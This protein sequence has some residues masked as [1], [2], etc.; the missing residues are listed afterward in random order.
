MIKTVIEN[1]DDKRRG[2]V[3]LNPA[4]IVTVTPTDDLH[5]A[6]AFVTPTEGTYEL[7]AV[8]DTTYERDRW[9]SVL[10]ER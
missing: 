9:I 5:L 10:N 1:Y 4:W 2:V 8:F 6:I 3:Y 7:V